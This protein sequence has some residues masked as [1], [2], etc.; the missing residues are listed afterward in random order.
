MGRRAAPKALNDSRYRRL[1]CVVSA[2]S[3]R[4]AL[5]LE[6]GPKPH[7]L[8]KSSWQALNDLRDERRLVAAG[9]G[10]FA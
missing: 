10:R 7:G 2:D 9:V 5:I 3:P 1:R 8:L 4:Q 6:Q